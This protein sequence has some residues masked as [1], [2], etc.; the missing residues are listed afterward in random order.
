MAG[1]S[2]YL[3]LTVDNSNSNIFSYSADPQVQGWASVTWDGND[4]LTSTLTYT[5][6]NSVD[7]TDSGSNNGLLIAIVFDDLQADL[8]FKIYT[9]QNN[10]SYRTIRLPGAADGTPAHMDIFLPFSSFTTGGGSGATFSN[11]G[12]VVMELDGT[13][14]AGVDVQIDFIEV[15]NARE[16]GDLPSSYSVI[17]AYHIPQGLRLGKIVDAETTY[18]ASTGANG[19]DNNPSGFDD[20]DGVQPLLLPWPAGGTGYVGIDRYGCPSFP[21]GCYINGW[22]DWNNDGDFNDALEHIV[23]NTQV[24]GDGSSYPSFTTPGSY[25]NGYYY[26]RFR[27]CPT[28]TGCDDP[29]ESPVTNGEVEDYR[30][31]LSPTAVELS[32]F[33]ASYRDRRVTVRWETAS[34]LDLVG[35]NIYR[36]TA[37]NGPYMRLNSTLIP[38][39][40]PGSPLGALYTWVDGQIRLGRV[41][42]YKL[43][44]LSMDGETTLHGPVQVQ[45]GTRV[46]PAPRPVPTVPAPVLP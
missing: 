38:A 45:T 42:Y 35:F 19:D 46:V 12:A 4:N 6:L 26:A 34:E 25:S 5:G 22:I 30:W 21:A 7:L 32:S 17:S 37:E 43:E 27:I 40:R 28:S 23:N 20:E 18:Q 44:Q 33:S 15:S 14:A 1:S 8:T 10:W 39:Q 24:Y 2:G 9:D 3:R 13:V 31:W 36:S 29:G 41:Y 16:Y 11:V